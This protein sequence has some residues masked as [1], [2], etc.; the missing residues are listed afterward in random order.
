MNQ[1]LRCL[2]LDLVEQSVSS[3][4]DLAQA[5]LE[6]LDAT[7]RQADVVGA[8]EVGRALAPEQTGTAQLAELVERGARLVQRLVL[9]ALARQSVQL[10]VDGAQIAHEPVQLLASVR[11]LRTKRLFVEGCDRIHWITLS[12]EG[13]LSR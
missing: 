7:S 4:L 2:L 11:E 12:C 8:L 5:L 10:A 6:R 13:S 9:L 3:F 1:P